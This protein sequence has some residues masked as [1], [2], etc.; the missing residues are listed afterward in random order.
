MLPGVRARDLTGVS[1]SALPASGGRGRE[2][3]RA[4]EDTASSLRDPV[5]KLRY[6]RS[7]MEGRNRFDRFG[8]VVRKKRLPEIIVGI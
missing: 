8:M 5:T 3:V 1:A 4:L 7:S 6:L 2:Y